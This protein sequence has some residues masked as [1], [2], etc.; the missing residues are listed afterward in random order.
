MCFE[1][2]KLSTMHWEEIGHNKGLTLTYMDGT[3][4]DAQTFRSVTLRFECA[5]VDESAGPQ[6]V[7]GNCHFVVVW[8]TPFACVGGI[9]GSSTGWVIFGS[10]SALILLYFCGGV[11]IKMIQGTPFGIDA[12]PNAG[13]WKGLSETVARQRN[14]WGGGSEE[15]TGLLATSAL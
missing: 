8:P 9:P 5:A 14:F 10:L 4:C 2:G 7:E 13:L 11:A 3:Q 15:E 6:H 1:L 12:L